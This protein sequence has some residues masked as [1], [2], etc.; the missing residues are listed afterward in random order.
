MMNF[1]RVRLKRMFPNQVEE[2]S[3]R[4]PIA[5]QGRFFAG[6]MRD[7]TSPAINIDLYQR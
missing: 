5:N 7:K 1:S 3:N 2:R 6:K 4:A